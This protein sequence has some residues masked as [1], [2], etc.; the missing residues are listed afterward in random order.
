MKSVVFYPRA[1][2]EGLHPNGQEVIVSIHDREQGP[3]QLQDGWKDILR[4]SFHDTDVPKDNYNVFGPEQAK[5]VMAFIEQHAD[6]ERVVV[7]CNMGV[8]RSAAV[9]MFISE[10][11]DRALFQQG[12]AFF[13][14][15]R[16]A[17]YNRL[18][19]STLNRE[20]W[21]SAP[22]AFESLPNPSDV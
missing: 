16:P 12:R 14:P 20:L 13:H 22:S 8:S 5:A 1:V 6:V 15:D 18:V 4:L 10:Q 2:A 11:Q 3:A 9:A 21:G 7:H 19:Y 17:Q